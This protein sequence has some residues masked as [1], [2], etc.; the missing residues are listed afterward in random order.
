MNHLYV[1]PAGE[2]VTGETTEWDTVM[3]LSRK[4]LGWCFPEDIEEL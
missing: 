4:G 3:I 2:I 1:L